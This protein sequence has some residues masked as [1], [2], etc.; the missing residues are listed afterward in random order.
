MPKTPT[1]SPAR[2]Q[3]SPKKLKEPAPA[4]YR[5][6]VKSTAINKS[7]AIKKIDPSTSERIKKCLQKAHHHGTGRSEMDAAMLL[8]KKLMTQY[9]ISQAEVLAHED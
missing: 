1:K 9:N 3:R 5:A 2:P 7:E 6:T 4:L 8:A